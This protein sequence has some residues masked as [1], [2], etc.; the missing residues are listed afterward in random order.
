MKN[1]NKKQC[2]VYYKACNVIIYVCMYD[3]YY[4]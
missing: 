1:K 2:L 3:V 4:K